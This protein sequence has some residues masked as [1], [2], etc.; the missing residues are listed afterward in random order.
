M[1]EVKVTVSFTVKI[2]NAPAEAIAQTVKMRGQV[3]M[4]ATKRGTV[5]GRST[6][7]TPDDITV[8]FEPTPDLVAEEPV[9]PVAPTIQPPL[10]V[11]VDI[12][13][14]MPVVDG[15]ATCDPPWDED[16]PIVVRDITDKLAE[17]E[18]ITLFN[19]S[20]VALYYSDIEEALSLDIDQVIR[21]CE[22]LMRD[23][24]ITTE[25]VVEPGEADE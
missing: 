25:D 12:A 1:G 16:T 4:L 18:I 2:P 17:V 6:N 19:A 7:L 21:V 8:D 13:P 14:A 23:K 10:N 20:E 24:R 11:D 22:Y 3:V 15:A 5:I 9:A